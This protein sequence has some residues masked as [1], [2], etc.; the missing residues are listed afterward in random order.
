M[1]K[2]NCLFF[3]KSAIPT[4]GPPVKVLNSNSA[5]GMWG[6]GIESQIIEWILK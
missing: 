6:T 3:D 1:N 5:Y 2:L 4:Y